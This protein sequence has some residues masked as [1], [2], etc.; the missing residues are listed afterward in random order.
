MTTTNRTTAGSGSTTA[1]VSGRH[2]QKPRKGKVKCVVWDLDNTLWSGI[3]LE[4]GE[5]T[6]R[7]EVL[8]LIKALDERGIVQSIASRNDPQAAMQCLESFGLGEYFLY[9]QINWNPKSTSLKTVAD[10]LRIGMDALVFID[11]QPFEL[12]EVAFAHPEVLC[13]DAREIDGLLS[14]PEL[15]PRLITDD[16]RNRRMMYLS[17]I[18]RDQARVEFAGTDEEFLATLGMVFTISP[19]ADGDL[20]RAEELTV[21]TNQLNSTGVTYSYAELEQFAHSPD[22]LLLIAGLTDKYGSYGKIGL[23]LIDLAPDVWHLRLLLMSC[24]VMSRG[25]GTVLLNHVKRLA[26]DHGARLRATFLPNDRNRVMYVTYRFSG[27]EEVGAPGD[28]PT[29]EADLT[30]IQEPPSYLTVVVG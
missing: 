4:D 16:A 30:S 2:R 7:P 12:D 25:V 3:L 6:L 15:T 1:S 21:R 29:L 11:D 5:V 20:Q 17:G 22:H 9:P 28:Q 10:S 24:R 27:F 23:A 14:R 26:R 18:K 8:P 13:V 19:A